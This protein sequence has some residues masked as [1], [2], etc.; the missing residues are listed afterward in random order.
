MNKLTTRSTR[1]CDTGSIA[2]AVEVTNKNVLSNNS[3][4]S[5]PTEEHELNLLKA[6]RQAFDA[7]ALLGDKPRNRLQKH[8]EHRDN[9]G[10]D[11]NLPHYLWVS[12]PGGGISTCAQALAEYMYY[13]ELFD[14]AGI[15]KCLEFKLLHLC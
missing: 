5:S 12:C 1:T 11:V 6:E 7:M 14:F 2:F 13:A 9:L 3:L 8:K 10:L 4:T 15:V